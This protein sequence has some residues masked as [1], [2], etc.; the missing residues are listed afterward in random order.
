M[1]AGANAAEAARME[2][3][4]RETL[5]SPT[6]SGSSRLALSCSALSLLL[7]SLVSTYLLLHH[8]APSQEE[9]QISPNKIIGE[10]KDKPRAHLTVKTVESND[11]TDGDYP[12]LGWED[13][14]GLA[15]TKGDLSYQNKFLLIPQTGFYFVYSQVLFRG[16]ENQRCE[17][18]IHIVTKL[19]PSYPEPMKLLSSTQTI[20]EKSDYKWS[21]PI[22]LGAM[23]QLEKG[24][25][26]M[27]NV[28]SVALVDHTN[29]HKTFFGAFLL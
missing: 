5:G 1:V 15:F 29:E 19:T 16:L 3:G 7:V 11:M 10:A 6:R 12:A 26:L 14:H 23:I 20:S 13:R 4:Q 27:V 9:R 28:S 25:R 21:V 2:E 17:K 24:D 8:T 18:I 22:Y